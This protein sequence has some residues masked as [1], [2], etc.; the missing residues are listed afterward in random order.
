M[1]YY[2]ERLTTQNVGNKSFKV[3]KLTHRS[4]TLCAHKAVFTAFDCICNT[5]SKVNM[6]LL[7]LQVLTGGEMRVGWAKPGCLP[8]QELGSDDQAFVFDGFKVPFYKHI[9]LYNKSH[10]FITFRTFFF[11]L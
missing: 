3:K 8:D 7:V 4:P 5:V 1:T 9:Q 2:V 11:Y 6:V 10:L